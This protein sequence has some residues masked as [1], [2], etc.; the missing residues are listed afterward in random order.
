MGFR[1]HRSLKILPGLKLNFSGGGVSLS[2]GVRGARVNFGPRGSFA[3]LGLPGTGLSYRQRIGGSGGKRGIVNSRADLSQIGSR[4]NDA[5]AS[6][7]LLE[8]V[9]NVSVSADTARQ[10]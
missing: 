1:F 3:T 2:A 10:Y 7:I 4:K 5:M 6:Q 8:G 9:Q